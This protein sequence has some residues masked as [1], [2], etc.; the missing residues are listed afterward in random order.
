MERRRRT[1]DNDLD[2]LVWTNDR[3]AK[4]CHSVDLGVSCLHAGVLS[5]NPQMYF[6]EYTETHTLQYQVKI[7]L[8]HSVSL[9][10][11]E[12]VRLRADS[13]PTWGHS[14]KL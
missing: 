3:I 9:E 4:W 8:G 5:E 7:Q 13:E 11:C 6:T 12:D 2:P 10:W 1:E 14:L